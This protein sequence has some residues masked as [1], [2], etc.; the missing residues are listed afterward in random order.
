MALDIHT[1]IQTAMIIAVFLVIFSIWRGIRLIRGART[2]PFFRMRRIQ[3]LRGWRSFIWALLLL[4]LV[5]LLR[6]QA[7]PVIYR[8]FPPT[9][10]LTPTRTIT[11]TP[12]ITQTKTITLTPSLTLTPKESY[13]PTASPT[14]HI[15]LAIELEFES[16]STPN[17]DAVFSQLTF[18]NGLDESYRPL[19]PGENFPNPVGHMYALFSYDKMVV[20]SQW[21]ALWYRG[22]ELVHYETIPWD[23]G[24]GGLGYTDWS[25]DPHE[26]YV[27]DYEVQL[28]V[29]TNWKRSG[30]FTVQGE[31]PSPI[32]SSTFTPSKT[33]TNTLTPSRTPFPT[34]T[35]IPTKTPKPTQ[36][37]YKS[38]TATKS[39]TPWPTLTRT[40][41]TPSITPW[42]TRT[43]LPTPA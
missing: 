12:T 4:G 5:V 29:G 43:R 15:P 7:E 35:P 14:P 36:T 30:I 21:T 1:G 17:P 6:F 13:T 24:S 26:W 22:D 32:P 31:P 39:R 2:L 40:P 37:P 3:M 10:T 25:P 19:N 18:T 34:A 9:L 23:G 41:V 28:F 42:P 20:G 38:P 27:G 11:L 16:T 8:F 33:P